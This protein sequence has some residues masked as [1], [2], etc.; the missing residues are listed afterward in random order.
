M[1]EGV[2]TLVPNH[3]PHPV[4]EFATSRPKSSWSC[5]WTTA[6]SSLAE[7]G[8]DLNHQTESWSC[9]GGDAGVNFSSLL[10][11]ALSEPR[12]GW[13]RYSIRG[14]SNRLKQ[15]IQFYL[16]FELVFPH[17]WQNCSQEGQ[18]I[19]GMDR[20]CQEKASCGLALFP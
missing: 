6:A 9:L 14:G 3:S 17:T 7:N 18:A 8:V 15:S 2:T 20:Q 13:L 19:L 10:Q 12:E 11:A 16:L 5:S 4:T 1:A